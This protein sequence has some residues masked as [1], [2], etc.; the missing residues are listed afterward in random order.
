MVRTQLSTFIFKPA[1][2]RIEPRFSKIVVESDA[3]N[4]DEDYS[5]LMGN[6]AEKIEIE[7]IIVNQ[8]DYGLGTQTEAEQ[9]TALNTILDG[10]V[11][12]S[13]HD[14]TYGDVTVLVEDLKIRRRPGEAGYSYL[15]TMKKKV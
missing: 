10:R 4:E 9:I 14:D 3:L 5:R 1:P 15:I 13:F 11:P 8:K 6:R 2:S 12:V 7:G